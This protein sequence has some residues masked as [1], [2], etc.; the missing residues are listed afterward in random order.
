MDGPAISTNNSL[1]TRIEGAGVSISSTSSPIQP[2]EATANAAAPTPFGDLPEIPTQEAID[3]IR[4]DFNFG[5]RVKIPKGDKSYRIRFVDLDNKCNLYDIVTPKGQEGLILS[6][7]RYYVNFRLLI[8]QPEDDRLLFAHDFNAKNKEVVLRF[9][10]PALGDAI[11]WFS[12][13]ERFQQKH[14]CNLVCVVADWFSNIVKKQYPQI[15]F[16]PK[17]PGKIYENSYATYDIGIGA[18]GDFDIQP[19]DHRYVGLHRLAARILDVGDEEIPPRFDL[20]APRKI[21]EKYVCIAVQASGLAKLW[22][23]PIGWD[24]VVDFLLSKGYRVLCMDKERFTGLGGTYNRKPEKAEDFT[25]DKPLQERIDII[26]DADFFVGLSSGLSWLAWGCHVPVVMISGFT[27][28]I[29][30]FHT[31]YRVFNRNVCNSCW[32][33]MTVKY[34]LADYWTCPRL[35]DKNNRFEC[36][37]MISPEKVI[38][39]IEKL[40]KENGK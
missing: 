37:A 22:N 34:D 38:S 24:A 30:E 25:G 16:A 28:P 8:S 20:S 29:T 9:P 7:K 1:A 27:N 35:G 23:N 40:I 39:V 33:D 36:S 6:K 10:S 19:I 13:M 21:Q 11:A 26:K 4:F 14:Q 15:R 12:Y 17:Q 3:G 32:N 18:I 5:L 2:G 31:P